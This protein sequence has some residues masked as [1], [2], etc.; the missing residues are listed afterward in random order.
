MGIVHKIRRP[1]KGE[2]E[3]WFIESLLFFAPPPILSRLSFWDFKED[4]SGRD[5]VARVFAYDVL[6][7]STLAWRQLE[8]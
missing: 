8:W 6:D 1:R 3:T 7:S 5:A 4:C 2:V